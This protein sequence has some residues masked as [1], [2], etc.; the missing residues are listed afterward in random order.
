MD[1]FN[2]PSRRKRF[3]RMVI[4]DAKN[5]VTYYDKWWEISVL[6]SIRTAVDWAAAKN[7][8]SF[9]SGRHRKN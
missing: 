3:E 7:A 4:E 6:P 9:T 1:Y 8:D 2:T 5:K